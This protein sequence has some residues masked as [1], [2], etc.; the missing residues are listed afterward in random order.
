MQGLVA[1]AIP[2]SAPQARFGLGILAILVAAA[3]SAALLFWA[4]RDPIFAAAFAAG[5]LAIGTPLAFFGRRLPA[6]AE[7]GPA[8]AEA[9]QLV[10]NGLPE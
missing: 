4:V 9:S 5:V 1:T 3:A 8:P 10:V 7:P 2:S 6:E